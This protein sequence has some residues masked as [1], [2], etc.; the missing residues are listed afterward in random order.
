VVAHLSE[1]KIPS[2]LQDLVS[3]TLNQAI[4]DERLRLWGKANVH[5]VDPARSLGWAA[6][7]AMFYEGTL[8]GIA[9]ESRG[10]IHVLSLR[11]REGFDLNQV[12]RELSRRLNIYDGGT[13]LRS[14]D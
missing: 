5:V 4:A 14:G 7:Y 10:D 3:R 6:N 12:L 8:V 2:M 13:S 11:N 1:N 9:T